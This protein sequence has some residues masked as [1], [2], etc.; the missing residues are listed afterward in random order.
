MEIFTMHLI[1]VIIFLSSILGVI[2]VNIYFL[3]LLISSVFWYNVYFSRN[4]SPRPQETKQL[5][6]CMLLINIFPPITARK[7]TQSKT[8]AAI[9]LG[10]NP[11]FIYIM[12][13]ELVFILF[14]IVLNP[15]NI[16]KT[17]LD[18]FPRLIAPSIEVESPNASITSYRQHRAFFSLSLLFFPKGESFYPIEKDKSLDET[19]LQ[20]RIFSPNASLAP[21]LENVGGIIKLRYNARHFHR[22][23]VFCAHFHV[24]VCR[25]CLII[26]SK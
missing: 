24:T 20:R 6:D 23:V 19:L 18:T 7:V 13:S 3:F 8:V 5:F 4:K 22:F 21:I 9:L 12:Y 10:K 1:A 25:C 26:L 11:S 17:K 15:T 14:S 2:I 16:L